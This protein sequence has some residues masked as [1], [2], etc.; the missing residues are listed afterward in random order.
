MNVK[1][2]KAWE[3]FLKHQ[4]CKD[5]NLLLH[6][7]ANDCYKTGQFFVAFRAF[8]ILEKIDKSPENWEG[9][10]GSAVGVFQLVIA[11]EIPM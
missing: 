11:K 8:D 10:R 4:H 5:A 6:L 7:I 9:K 1:A 2:S 3:L